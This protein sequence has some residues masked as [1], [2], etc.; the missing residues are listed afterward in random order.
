MSAWIQDAVLEP[1]GADVFSLT[2]GESTRLNSLWLSAT[3]FALLLSFWLFRTLPDK[4][5][6]QRARSGLIIM[7][8]GMSTL[9]L[10]SLML[11]LPLL[12]LALLCFGLGFGIYTYS[13]LNLMSCMTN[14]VWAGTLM[15][16]WTIA[17]VVSR[18]LGIS[19]GGVLRDVLLILT[20]SDK[21]AYSMLFA[22]SAIGLSC[23][24]L[25]LRKVDFSALNSKT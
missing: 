14:P 24:T 1:F 18:G 3:L 21:L 23:A 12:Y 2:I 10:S 19:L 13:G 6:V 5:H 4:A 11:S 22:L 20:L 16:F 25:L 15:G 9:A 8:A 7:S 17:Q